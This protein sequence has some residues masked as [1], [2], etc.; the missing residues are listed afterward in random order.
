MA[1]LKI[2]TY[3]KEGRLIRGTELRPVLSMGKT[4]PLE[5]SRPEVLEILIDYYKG[6]KKKTGQ[7]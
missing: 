6:L 3:S 1:S 4:P 2:S 7:Q 5:F